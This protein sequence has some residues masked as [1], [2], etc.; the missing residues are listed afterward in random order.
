[1]GTIKDYLQGRKQSMLQADEECTQLLEKTQFCIKE[2]K[3]FFRDINTYI[4]PYDIPF[5]LNQWNDLFKYIDN[6][7]FTNLKIA[8]NYNMLQNNLKTITSILQSKEDDCNSWNQ[9]YT[10]SKIQ[11]AHSL[12]CPTEGRDLDDQQL[13]CIVMDAKNSLVVAGAGTGKTTAI[14][15]KIKYL[16]KTNACEPQD[17][18]VLS[19]TN[20][21]ASEMAE[22]IHKE[23]NATIQAVTF[24]KLGLN[25]I[26]EVN[27]VMPKI[28]TLNLA[29]FIKSLLT[30]FSRDAS[31]LSKLISL[32]LYNMDKE[33]SEFDFTMESEYEEF[34]QTNPP[35]TLLHEN[36]KSYAEVDIANFLF[37]NGIKYIYE[38]PYQYDTAT[39]DFGGYV[40]DFYL[41][42][43]DIYI[44]HY[45][46][47]R[48]GKVAPYFKGK[49]GKDASEC[50]N[51]SIRWK[52]ETHKKYGTKMIEVFYYEK[53]EGKLL[54]T[55]ESNLK[56]M[57]VTFNPLDN[58]TLW[59]NILKENDSILDGLAQLIDTIINLI[60]SNAYTWDIVISKNKEAAP[61][62]R[63]KNHL[64]LEIVA[65]IYSAYCKT[66][67]DNHEIDFN[68][69]I[70]QA[71]QYIQSNKYLH[72]YKYVIVDEYQDIS[73]SRFNLIKS[74]RDQ[75]FFRLFCV[76]DDWQSIYRFTGSDIGFILNF[77]KYWGPTEESR[78]ETTY[79]FSRSLIEISGAFI[80]QNPKQ[81]RKHLQSKNNND[82]FAL[83]II[84]GYT[85]KN[86]IDFMVQKLDTLPQKSSVY[87]IGRNNF[88]ID[89]L[90]QSPS[91]TFNYDN[92]AESKVVQ[93][94]ERQDLQMQ[95]VTAHKSKGLQA[96]YVFIINNRN[97]RMGFPSK[98]QDHPIIDLF[99]GFNDNYEYS[100]ERRLF[101]VALTRAKQKVWL[102]VETANKSVFTRELESKWKPE[103]KAE[104]FTCP[105]CG[106]R[107]IKRTN[108]NGDSFLG[109]SNYGT[110]G[111]MYTRNIK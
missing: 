84:E 106:G 29:N 62:Q 39:P 70:N 89:L 83:D 66:L 33:K 108:K 17:I 107:L 27:Q 80:M 40:P 38:N 30:L 12:I 82:R 20:A 72:Q 25:I 98:M 55:L 24:H 87:F 99:L 35:I 75:K 88:D 111:C 110:K 48:E 50:Y 51:E 57:E 60:K 76:G 101:Y 15:G 19:F 71:T 85:S 52:R 23:T 56:A 103:I 6:S 43:Y 4:D 2:Y 34:L 59:E 96:D 100:E 69:M 58:K 61:Y 46:I 53:I 49:D 77:T 32:F 3:A 81:I 1:M 79:R 47:D 67:A 22:R 63:F 91:L 42:D 10:K 68:D 64:L 36:V 102:L 14:I 109:C 93:Y 92:A 74:M 78:I 18:L 37:R 65:P 94:S 41:P 90:K 7:K 86:T 97:N 11:Y 104:F 105:D 54:N 13:S 21:S 28:T 26:S 16:L 5:W 44:E 95:F 9:T 45:G 73:M 31:F 8:H